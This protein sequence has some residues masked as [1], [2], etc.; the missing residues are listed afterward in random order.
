MGELITISDVPALVERW[1]DP[2]LRYATRRVGPTEAEEIVQ[3]TW[4]RL[5]RGVQ[6]GTRLHPDTVKS[7]L[8][9]VAFNLMID[10]K[11][12]AALIFWHPLEN[13]EG[14]LLADDPSRRILLY[15]MAQHYLGRFSAKKQYAVLLAYQDYTYAE[16]GARLGL[17]ELAAKQLVYNARRACVA[18]REKEAS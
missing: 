8:Y 12:R 15:E 14:E 10:G 17:S 4:F 7:W 18:L 1:H 2:L 13:V 11:R 5:I 9:R 3:E 16:I 6:E